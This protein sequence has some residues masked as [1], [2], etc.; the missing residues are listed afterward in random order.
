MMTQMKIDIEAIEAAVS[1]IVFNERTIRWTDAGD[2][3]LPYGNFA[4]SRSVIGTLY[5]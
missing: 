1:N 3:S 2:R 4:C 5:E